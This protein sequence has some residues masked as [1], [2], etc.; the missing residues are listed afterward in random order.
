MDLIKAQEEKDRLEALRIEAEMEEI[1]L[2]RQAEEN[3]D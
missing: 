3:S 2:E 1:E